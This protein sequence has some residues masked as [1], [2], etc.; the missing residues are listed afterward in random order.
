MTAN[1]VNS[2]IPEVRPEKDFI[3]I[4]GKKKKLGKRYAEFFFYRGR[5]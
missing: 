2:L 3:K 1:K 4:S 5:N